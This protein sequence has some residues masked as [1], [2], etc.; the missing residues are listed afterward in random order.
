MATVAAAAL[1]KE[2]RAVEQRALTAA[3]LWC[4]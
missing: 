2:P 3:A 4:D 1:Q